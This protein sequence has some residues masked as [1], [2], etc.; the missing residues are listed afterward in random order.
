MTIEMYLHKY[1]YIPFN[2]N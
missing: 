2:L 1:I